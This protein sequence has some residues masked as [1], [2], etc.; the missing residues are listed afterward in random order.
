MTI[1]PGGG[2]LWGAIR[3]KILV[4]LCAALL[5]SAGAEAQAAPAVTPAAGISGAWLASS[6]LQGNVI[7]SRL[8]LEQK[9]ATL[10][11][12]FGPAKLTGTV[13]GSGFRFVATYPDGSTDV[14]AGVLGAASLSGVIV[15]TDPANPHRPESYTFTA[16]LAQQRPSTPP[17]RFDFAPTVFYRDFSALHAPVLTISPGDTV[18]TTTVDAGGADEKGV[19]RS[20]GG[21]PQTGPFFVTSIS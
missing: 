19:K 8:D 16:V 3:L 12:T 2:V 18:H 5:F 7:Y 20:L 21:N 4:K 13:K 11:G 17:R 9:G 15:T 14:A 10:T 1:R 6:N